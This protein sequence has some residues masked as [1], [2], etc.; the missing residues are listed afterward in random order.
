LNFP[1][2]TWE[3]QIVATNVCSFHCEEH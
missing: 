1:G 2:K 3:E